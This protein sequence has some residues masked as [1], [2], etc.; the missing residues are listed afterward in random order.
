MCHCLLH[1]TAKV[2]WLIFTWQLVYKFCYTSSK[3]KIIGVQKE[4]HVKHVLFTKEVRKT[5][6]EQRVLA[7]VNLKKTCYLT[8][9]IYTSRMSFIDNMVDDSFLFFCKM[10]V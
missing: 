1:L 8:L 5:F 10:Y 9:S 7:K 6:D 3:K 4:L 2:I